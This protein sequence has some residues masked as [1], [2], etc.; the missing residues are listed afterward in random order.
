M[1]DEKNTEDLEDV[2]GGGADGSE[3]LMD[4]DGGSPTGSEG[5]YDS[6]NPINSPLDDVD[7]GEGPT[8]SDALGG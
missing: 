3:I 1:G 2:D 6:N 5:A 7:G 4:A 8:D